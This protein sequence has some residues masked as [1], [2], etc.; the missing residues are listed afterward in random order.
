MLEVLENIHDEQLDTTAGATLIQDFK[1]RRFLLVSSVVVNRYVRLCTASILLHF[2]LKPKQGYKGRTQEVPIH[3]LYLPLTV[4][5]V[6]NSF[7]EEIIAYIH[8]HKPNA[9][10]VCMWVVSLSSIRKYYITV[11]VYNVSHRCISRTCTK[12]II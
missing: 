11:S 9:L 5:Q 2:D 12:T 6:T 10:P 8:K 7:L 4:P 3:I 1:E